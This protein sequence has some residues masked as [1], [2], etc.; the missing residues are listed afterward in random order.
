MAIGFV[1]LHT[2][3]PDQSWMEDTQLTLNLSD[4]YNTSGAVTAVASAVDNIS[5]GFNGLI[6]TLTPESNFFGTRYV[7]TGR[8]PIPRKP[9]GQ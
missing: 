6:A 5:I 4:Y 3:I 9:N 1:D 8:W 7:C 2:S